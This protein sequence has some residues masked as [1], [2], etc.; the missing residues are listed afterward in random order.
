LKIELA[1]K[2]NLAKD[3]AFKDLKRRETEWMKR[4]EE[5]DKQLML[6]RGDAQ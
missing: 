4:A 1:S 6:Q 3:E 2:V 5:K